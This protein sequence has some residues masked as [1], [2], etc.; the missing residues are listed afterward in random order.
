MRF[1]FYKD[2]EKVIKSGK[3]FKGGYVTAS[4]DFSKMTLGVHKQLRAHA[5]DAQNAL[6]N[7][8]AQVNR[9]THYKVTYRRVVLTYSSNKGLS[10]FTRSF[11]LDYIQGNDKWYIPPGRT[12][13]SNVKRQ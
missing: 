5:R 3:L 8:E 12:T 9:I 6:N 13:Y 2:K 4:E 1:S 7:D 11:S 10:P